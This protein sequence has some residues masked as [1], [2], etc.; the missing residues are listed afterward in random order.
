MDG[1]YTERAETRKIQRLRREKQVKRQRR[2]IIAILFAVVLVIAVLSITH[3]AYASA[4]SNTITRVKY[5]KSI[6][7]YNGDTLEAIT[8]RY[9]TEEYDSAEQ[10]IYEISCINHLTED[11]VLIAG[12]YLTVPYYTDSIVKEFAA[13]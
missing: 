5:Y 3:F 4:D 13:N 12:N 6:M 7:I 2:F 11:P 10:Y 9:L 1:Y 8:S